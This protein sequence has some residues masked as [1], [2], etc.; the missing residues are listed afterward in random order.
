MIKVADWLIL[1]T[2]QDF[3]AYWNE[4]SQRWNH[5]NM[6]RP[7]YF[8]CAFRY[9]ENYCANSVCGDWRE[10][11]LEAVKAQIREIMLER[12]QRCARS[13]AKKLKALENI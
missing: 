13:Y 9:Q 6:N 1:E 8:P 11:P 5:D 3:L 10:E 2:E 7:E 4:A 12:Q